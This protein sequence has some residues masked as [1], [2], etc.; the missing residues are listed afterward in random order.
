MPLCR[1][2]LAST[3]LSNISFFAS[4]VAQNSPKPFWFC[5]LVGR[6]GDGSMRAVG[7]HTCHQLYLCEQQHAGLLLMQMEH[8]CTQ[9]LLLVQVG[10]PTCVRAGPLLLRPGSK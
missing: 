3:N 6:R 10:M 2:K 9:S 1:I 7:K 8:M 4:A 5:R